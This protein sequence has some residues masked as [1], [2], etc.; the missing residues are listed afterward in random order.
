MTWA[1]YTSWQPIAGETGLVETAQTFP[2]WATARSTALHLTC[3]RGTRYVSVQG[4][5]DVVAAEYDRYTNYW[6]EYP[7]VFGPCGNER[8]PDGDVCPGVLR[9]RLGAPQLRCE[10]CEGWT[11]TLSRPEWYDLLIGANRG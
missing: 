8:E 2:D 9:G 3:C 11:G 7:W 10:V 4:P 5:D 6:R 1:V